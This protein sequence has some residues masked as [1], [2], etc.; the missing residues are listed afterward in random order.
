[1]TEDSPW[2][3]MIRDRYC[4]KGNPRNWTNKTNQSHIWRAIH[5]TKQILHRF[6]KWN[7]GN[8]RKIDI[9]RDWWVG[10]G[11]LINQIRY[12][13]AEKITVDKL[14]ND[15]G[16]WDVEAISN[17]VYPDT[18]LLIHNIPIS[19]SGNH[20]CCSWSPNPNGN[21]SV[22]T[23]YKALIIFNDDHT[24]LHID[25]SWLWKLKIPPKIQMFL[26]LLL[27][28]KILTAQ[29][30]TI[31]G[32][33]NN[34]NWKGCG[35]L[36]SA[37]HIFRNCDVALS[38]W[39]HYKIQDKP[40]LHSNSFPEWIKINLTNKKT[41]QHE[42][43]QWGSLFA[44]LIW[45]LWCSRNKVLF[46]NEKSNHNNILFKS[47]FM[48]KDNFNALNDASL[49]S[50]VNCNN[51]LNANSKC[52]RN[53]NLIQWFCPPTGKLKIN[54]DG[55]CSIETGLGC[56]GGIIRDDKGAWIEGFCG[57]IGGSNPLSAE[58]WGLY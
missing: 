18:A 15:L 13:H 50:P 44:F 12:A 28:N 16:C 22:G 10:E 14:I 57:R 2:V 48:N 3:R 43:H 46:E 32:I 52:L 4:K 27:Q 58:L 19:A 35:R 11:P 29:N 31:R 41:I 42:N 8:G 25:Y 39:D 40:Q 1:M 23:A 26:W 17:R 5:S 24:D 34:P 33:T 7:L 9:F 55:G 51:S 6:I 36:E 53:P 54:T 47:F 49:L 38:V 30:T 21:F 20:D 56:Y 45:N 37:S